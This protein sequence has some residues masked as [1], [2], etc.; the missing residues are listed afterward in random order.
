MIG[1][2][3]DRPG[4]V[5]GLPEA[6]ELLAV[7]G[8]DRSGLVVTSEGALVRI[9]HVIPPNPLILSADER[10]HLAATFCHVIGRLRAGQTL[11]FYI[12]ARPIDLGQVLTESRAQVA[13]WGGDV[14]SVND[15][16]ADPLTASRWRLH[17]A[18]EESLRL[19]CDDQAAVALN[20]YVVV[21][22]VPGRR[23]ARAILN[24]LRP[25]G[26]KLPVASLERELREH[27][28][29][30]RES[31]AAADAVR[32][33]LDGLSMPTRFLDGEEV[34]AL[35]WGRFNP[36]TADAHRRRPRF[37]H[38]LLGELD[39]EREREEARDAAVALRER[40][41]MSSLDFGRSRHHVEVDRDAEQTI[42]AATTADATTM[43]W[44]MGA[45]LT[46]QP[47]TLS[48]YVHALDRGAERQRVKR[49]HRRLFAVNRTAEAKGR[50]PDFDRYAQEHES[51]A[52]LQ[53]MAGHDRTALFRVS[54]YQSIRVPGPEPKLAELSEAVDYCAEQIESMSDC[55]IN[56]GEF[57][58][59]ELW[60]STLPLGRDV[61]GRTRRYA[62]RNVG[63]TVPLVGLGCGSPSGI[64]FAFS[65]PGRTLERLDPYDRTHANYTMLVNGRSG[66]GKTLAANVIVARCIAQGARGFVLDRA[67]HYNVLTEL[68]AGAR[69][70]EIGADNSPYGINPWDVD[71]PGDVSLEKIAF[72]VSLHGVMMGDEGLTTME[73]SQLGA[74]IRA[75]YAQAALS[76]VAP[77]ESLLR[78]ELL[79]RSDDERGDG[80]GEVAAV[81]RNLAERLGEFCGE[82]SY[83]Y[84]LDRDTT[85]PA[86]SP[87]VVFDTRRCPDVVLKPVMFAILEYIT[88]TIERHRDGNADTAAAADAPKFAGKSVLLLDEAWHLVGRRETGEYANDLARRARHL[89]LFLIVVS[90]QLSDFATEHGLALIRNSTMQLLLNQH[91][92]ELAFVQEALGLTDEEAAL[93][94]RLKTVKGSHSQMF[95]VNG[96]RGK[97]RVALRLG[98]TEYW[99][100]TSDP[101]RDAPLRDAAVQR[102]GGDVWRAV[103]E[104]AAGGVTDAGV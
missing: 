52:L 100:Y 62:T 47:F 73:R 102:N 75:V 14:T 10:T 45:M 4:A 39:G 82:G 37:S 61:A 26:W 30:V 79:R 32:A 16:H 103:A 99:C 54:I 11:Q 22:Y 21:P 25:G 5:G 96:T 67:G 84:L 59:Y 46:W 3:T 89:G 66:S 87:L 92:D 68:V 63:D 31:L 88:R 23:T 20:A 48:V 94:G 81:L 24:A 57:Q 93:V 80:A 58:Q 70:V 49:G 77:H 12:E 60:P 1:R 76:G 72:L 104:L 50:V 97:G 42:Y 9:V 51:E 2:Q 55:R 13:A 29:A 90:Q 53:E 71:D 36:T 17:A 18:M 78:D 15:P 7:E 85:V 64:P 43:G 38:E 91:P 40:I 6:G 98:P 27:R 101:L 44:L 19:H 83:A 86:D 33:E 56:R 34:A 65:D 8:I 95:W 41:A 69:Q 28:R 74:A 35:L